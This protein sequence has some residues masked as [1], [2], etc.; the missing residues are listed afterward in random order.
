[1]AHAIDAG[2]DDILAL[3]AHD[4]LDVARTLSKQL[5]FTVEKA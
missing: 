2:A 5:A 4:D 1:V 3:P